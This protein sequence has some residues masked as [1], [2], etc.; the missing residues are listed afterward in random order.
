MADPIIAGIVTVMIYSGYVVLFFGIGTMFL[1]L[2]N[3]AKFKTYKIDPNYRPKFT[4]LT[5][6]Y[7]EEQFIERTI[8]AFLNTTYP[9]KLKRLADLFS[10]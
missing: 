7:N 8:K 4:F 3:K 6:A 1:A 9:V 2:F 5:P 10:V